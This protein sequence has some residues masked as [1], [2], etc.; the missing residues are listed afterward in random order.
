MPGLARILLDKEPTIVN[1]PLQRVC[2]IATWLVCATFA[3]RALTPIGYMPASATEGGPFILCPSGS[4]A[5]LVQYLESRRANTAHAGHHHHGDGA[6]HERHG[7]GSECPI[8]ASFAT[9]VPTALPALDTLLP[10]AEAPV[11]PVVAPT[12]SVAETRYHSRA[13]PSRRSA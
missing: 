5:E 11:L 3:C 12:V 7:D 10:E 6:D 8:G 4:Q 9:A 1:K 2:R 13:P